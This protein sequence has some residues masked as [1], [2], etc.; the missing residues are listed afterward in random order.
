MIN[1]YSDADGVY[2]AHTDH[3]FDVAPRSASGW[4]GNW[5]PMKIGGAFP[6]WWSEDLVAETNR[7]TGYPLVRPKWL[8]AWEEGA[9]QQLAPALSI[10]DGENWPVVAGVEYDDPANWRWWKLDAIKKD[11][12]ASRPEAFIWIEDGVPFDPNTVG[13][14]QTVAIPHLVISPK[15]AVGVTRDHIT[16]IEAFIGEVSGRV[17][18]H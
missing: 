5:H 17:R 1:W 8:T 6:G 14:L 18:T 7:L 4:D 12:T 16:E 13:W 10:A 3:H 11:L 2:N 9:P 15:T